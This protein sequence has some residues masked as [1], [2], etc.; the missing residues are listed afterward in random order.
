M[1]EVEEKLGKEKVKLILDSARNG[2][3]SDSQ[4]SSIADK[5]GRNL[6]GPNVVF[7]N[8]RRRMERDRFAASDLLL[9][10]IL[11]DW[12]DTGELYDLSPEEA[13]SKMVETF[14]DPD[15]N[16]RPLAKQLKGA[17]GPRGLDLQRLGDI[18]G[19]RR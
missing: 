12:W 8:H 1:P 11:S 6:D 19:E 4:L 16:L 17:D 10:S 7:G 5:L 2:D 3:I 15:I 9:K 13:L 18:Q 14:Q